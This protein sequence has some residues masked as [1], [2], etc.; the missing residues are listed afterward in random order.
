MRFS[1]PFP[2]ADVVK[3]GMLLRC[4]VER[5][6]VKN[7]VK[8]SA[9]FW[10]QRAVLVSTF[11]GVGFG[12]L[13]MLQ[14]AAAAPDLFDTVV[15]DAGHGGKDLGACGSKGLQ[16]KELVLDIAKRVAKLLRAQDMQIVMTREDDTFVSLDER[17]MIA[18]EIR[19]DLFLSIHANA[20]TAKNVHGIET[21]FLSLE[22][23]DAEA[24]AVASRENE[25]FAA[26][27][28]ASSPLSDDP[29][30]A[31]LGDLVMTEHLVE[32]DQFAK[33]AQEKLA[34]LSGVPSRGVKQAPFVVLMGVQMPAS[35][36]EIGFITNEEEE[37]KLKAEA[38]REE[39]AKQLVAAVLE[40]RDRYNAKRGVKPYATSTR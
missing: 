34:Q 37:K 29:L 10:M 4:K 22:S 32:S 40:Y 15:I 19:G 24:D 5:R 13:G 12:A 18:N 21:Y 1:L 9:K 11:I 25:S 28:S 30:T 2:R 27:R 8:V 26:E 39:I 23:S 33:L 36:V 16:E 14:P 35:L 31:I 20:T 6:S 17:T 38:H 7:F 3:K